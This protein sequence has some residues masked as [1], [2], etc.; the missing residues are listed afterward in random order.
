MVGCGGFWI[1]VNK[2]R[3]IL[4]LFDLNL[5]KKWQ[6]YKL[7]VH[8]SKNLLIKKGPVTIANYQSS[9]H[10]FPQTHFYIHNYQWLLVGL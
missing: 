8:Q 1:Y 6:P 4:K 7:V 2:L 9:E 5:L 3:V 10:F